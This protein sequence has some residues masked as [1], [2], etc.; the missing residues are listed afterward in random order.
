MALTVHRQCRMTHTGAATEQKRIQRL[1]A[2]GDS[3]HRSDAAV[4]VAL[5]PAVEQGDSAAVQQSLQLYADPNSKLSDSAL[6]RN[7]SLRFY[8]GDTPLHTAARLG[9]AK[10]VKRLIAAGADVNGKDD[11]NG[12]PLLW[13]IDTGNNSVIQQLLTAGADIHIAN[14]CGE[15]PLLYAAGEGNIKPVK[16]LIAA[17]ADVNASAGCGTPIG[18]AAY[19][20]HIERCRSC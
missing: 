2:A 18:Q 16:H 10:I 11:N 5:H 7:S 20:G 1:P 15:T 14:R 17:G 13:A 4:D 8:R 9:H 19:G 12:G 6:K 3:N